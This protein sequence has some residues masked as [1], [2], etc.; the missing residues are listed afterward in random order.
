M[1]HE[2]KPPRKS[3]LDTS[4]EERRQQKCNKVPVV[5]PANAIVQ[6]VERRGAEITESKRVCDRCQL[7][8]RRQRNA[9]VTGSGMRGLVDPDN[10]PSGCRLSHFSYDRPSAHGD[11]R[12]S[13]PKRVSQMM[14]SQNSMFATLHFLAAG[15]G[16]HVHRPPKKKT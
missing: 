16:V 13:C 1:V 12:G 8:S 15:N 2:G 3:Q 7:Y 5:T 9:C 10:Q 11:M 4:Q 6:P 14:R